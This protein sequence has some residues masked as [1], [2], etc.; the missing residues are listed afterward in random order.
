M[1]HLTLRSVFALFG[2]VSFLAAAGPAAAQVGPVQPVMVQPSG[3]PEIPHD[4]PNF[5][6]DYSV[7]MD[8]YVNAQGKV[9]NVVVT[10]ATG[11]VEADGVAATFMRDRV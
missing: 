7:P 6:E 10:Q 3:N 11:N 8:V 2:Y 4:R 9:T 5:Q 1:K